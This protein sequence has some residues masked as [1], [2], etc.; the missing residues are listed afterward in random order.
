MTY[1]FE[2]SCVNSTAKAINDMVDQSRKVSYRTFI[3]QVGRDTVRT[4]Y[5]FNT[6]AWGRN[7]KGLRL[8]DDWHVRYYK[9]MYKG[10]LCYYADQS[11]IEYVFVKGR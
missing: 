10:Q 2:T 5:P 11:A 8:K 1:Y 6:Y 9:S 3:A 7:E 4:V